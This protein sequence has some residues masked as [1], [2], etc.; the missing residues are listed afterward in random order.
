M[1]LG[2]SRF[3]SCSFLR[4]PANILGLILSGL[5]RCTGPSPNLLLCPRRVDP[6]GPWVPWEPRGK[7]GSQDWWS[8][9][10]LHSP[11][12]VRSSACQT[13]QSLALLLICSCRKLE[14]WCWL[15]CC[16]GF[17]QWNNGHESM[18][19]ITKQLEKITLHIHSSFGNLIVFTPG[20]EGGLCVPGLQR[21]LARGV[22]WAC[23]CQVP[24]TNCH[25]TSP[26]S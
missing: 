4:F 10:S 3:T 22:V 7:R 21:V 24:H 13:S 20:A 16:A 11:F 25:E 2:W 1:V 5:S 18:L 17:V 26:H 14:K 8:H 9:R 23:P 12:A 6:P 15:Y 19:A